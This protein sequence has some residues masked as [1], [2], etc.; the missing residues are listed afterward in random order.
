MR[1]LL[2]LLILQ[3]VWLMARSQKSIPKKITKNLFRDSILSNHWKEPGLDELP[4]I[5]FEETEKTE[6]AVSVIPSMLFANR[7]VFMSMAGF[8]FSISRF[9][10]RGYEGKLFSTRFNGISLNGLEDGVTQWNLLTGLNE[11]TKN[12]QSSLGL[13][14]TAFAFGNIGS[15]TE[16]DARA[17][18]QRVQTVF[19]NSFSNRSFTNRWSFTHTVGFN[20]KGLAYSISGSFRYANEGYIP[21]SFYDGKSYF[22]AIDKKI[23]EHMLL[24]FTILGAPLVNG[25]Q[26]PVTKETVALTGTP[27]YN[28]Y[29]GYESGKKRNANIRLMHQPV[30]VINF[31]NRINNHNSWVTSLGW[32]IGGRSDTGIDWYKAADPRADYYRYLPGYQQDSLLKVYVNDAIKANPELLQIKWSRLINTNRNSHATLVDANGILGNSIHGKRSHYIIEERKSM[33]TRLELSSVYHSLLS[34]QYAFSAGGSFVWQRTHQY[35]KIQDLLGGDFYVDW[36]Q[37]AE[38]DFPN[39]PLLMQ[40]DLNRPNRIL[41]KG[42]AFGY[43]YLLQSLQTKGWVQLAG[44]GKKIDFF[45]GAEINYHNYQREGLVKNGLFPDNS[46]GKSVLNEFTGIGLKAGITYKYNGRKYFYLQ[47]GYFVKP[48]LVNDVYISPR[49]RDTRQEKIQNEKIITTEMGYVWNAPA[50]KLRMSGYLTSYFDGMNINTFYHDGFGNFVNYALSGINKL[51]V[52]IECGM[53]LSISEQWSFTTA[54]SVSRYVYNSRQKLIVTADNDASVIERGLIYS[55][56][57]RVGGTPQEAY[58]AGIAYQFSGRFFSN[59]TASYFRQQ[60]LEFNPMRRTYNALAGLASGTNQWNKV[61]EQTVLPEQYTVD[62]LLGTTLRLKM[63]GAGSKQ[64]IQC[65]ASINNLLNNQSVISGGYE[66]LRFDTETKNPEKFPPK[67][68]YAMGLNYSITLNLR[69]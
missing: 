63:F 17:S 66:Q 9:S 26:G 14:P 33:G 32:V 41:H 57:F 5:G 61:I 53:E 43:D 16:I 25:K 56:N 46:A 52:G 60:W 35:K 28:P 67:F 39:N 24:S 58:G 1:K 19:T 45:S 65:I 3:A 12:S 55:K 31:D 48:P 47:A 6:H 8:H 11:V 59:L 22:L 15:V 7:D 20:K 40:N 69:L 13:R 36:N 10:I 68:F 29:W 18:K 62:L 34:N 23:N 21:G 2:W 49:T 27:Y 37:F 42:D 30:M 51:H 44:V 54:I 38:R 50:V 64:T 4:V